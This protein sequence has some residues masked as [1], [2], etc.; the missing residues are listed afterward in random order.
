MMGDQEIHAVSGVNIEIRRGEYVAIMGPSGSGKSTL[1]N[2]IG[3]L[4]TPTKGQ[5]FLNGKL[6]SEMDDDELARIRNKEIGFVF[7]TFNL[8][9]RATALHNV[10][11]PLIY[12]G[13]PAAKGRS[14]RA[15]ALASVDL[16]QRMHAQAQR[17]VRWS[18]AARRHRPR[19]GQPAVHPAGRRA[20]RRPGLGDRQRDHGAVRATVPVRETP[21]CWSPTS[22]TSPCMRT[23]LFI[24]ATAK[25]TATKL[26][27]N[28]N[29]PWDRGGASMGISE[30]EPLPVSSLESNKLSLE[31]AGFAL[32]AI[33]REATGDVNA[34][35]LEH[36]ATVCCLLDPSLPDQVVGD[37]Q[38]L[39]AILVDLL[40]SAIRSAAAGEVKLSVFPSGQSEF[41]LELTFE[42]T[43]SAYAP[44]GEPDASAP[45]GSLAPAKKIAQALGGELGVHSQNGTTPVFWCRIPVQHSSSRLSCPDPRHIGGWP[46]RRP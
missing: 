4:D 1:M 25:W 6:V 46:N 3:C 7:Q 43:V 44:L 2:L 15:K 33:I 45:G 8:L 39:R 23:E 26:S 28:R 19:S 12:A 30:K 32:T 11:L 17:T 18:A 31:T 16:E 5:Y 22:R 41:T 13:I 35:V 21:S 9:P 37:S 38:R 36:S 10:E 29:R 14:E 42:V 24:S 40:T 27:R 20:D 34:L